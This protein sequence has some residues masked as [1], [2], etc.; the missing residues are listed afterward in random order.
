MAHST[1]FD[2]EHKVFKV[3]GAHFSL[4]RDT[5]KPA[6]FVRMGDLDVAIS[7]DSL[8][9]EFQIPEGSPDSELLGVAER[10]LRY[11]KTIRPGDSIPK[12]LLDGT[13]SWKIKQRHHEIARSRL[14]V[15]LISWMTGQES[16]LVDSQQL[17]QIADDPET[18][19][20][21]SEATSRMAEQLDLPVER[22]EEITDRIEKLARDLAFIEALREHYEKVGAISRKL[23]QLEHVYR[24]DQSIQESVLRMRMLI[25]SPITWFVTTFDAVDANT[26]ELLSMLKNLDLQIKFIR[27][28]RDEIHFQLMGWEEMMSLWGETKAER[29]EA[30]EAALRK[31][32]HFLARN[33]PQTRE[34]PLVTKQIVNEQGSTAGAA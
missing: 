11:V 19:R 7:L 22:R 17:L 15:Q 29:G 31:T 21:V 3:E 10:G 24:G 5:G 18:K 9:R 26:G 1:H 32:Y 30:T 13:A 20:R 2:F 16:V 28:S 8:R 34:W 27:D 23:D 6:F 14:T 12:E 25:R 4:S 33:Y